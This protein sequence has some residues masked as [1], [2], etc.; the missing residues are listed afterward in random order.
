[1]SVGAG[2]DDGLSNV[3]V[4]GNGSSRIK[5]EKSLVKTFCIPDFGFSSWHFVIPIR[6]RGIW[7]LKELD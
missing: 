2:S 4:A 5:T 3:N 7:I 6:A 1:M